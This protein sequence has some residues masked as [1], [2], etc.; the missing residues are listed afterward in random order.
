MKNIVLTGFMASGKT[1]TS[2]DLSRIT[3]F[4]L[5]DTDDMI[6]KREGKSINEIFS[7]NG[8]EYFRKAESEIIKEVSGFKNSVISTGGGVVL[9]KENI[10]NLRVNS[11]IFC[12]SPSFD[13]IK[14]R[15]EEA[16][17][18]RPLMKNAGIDEIYQRFLQRQPYYDNCDYK[19]D[20]T[21]VHTPL[22]IAKRI[23]EIYKEV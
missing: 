22:M 7:E 2:K 5:V 9:N 8:E 3:S 14:E 11:I 17:K 20:I 18:S 23:W 13:V 4:K 19:I 12:L 1:E 10:E 15:M 16:A 6:V 21:S